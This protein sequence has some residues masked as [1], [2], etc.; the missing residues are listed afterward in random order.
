MNKIAH[1]VQAFFNIINPCNM[2]RTFDGLRASLR[3]W[4]PSSTSQQIKRPYF[5][6]LCSHQISVK[7][8]S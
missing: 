4:W 8:S 6:Y 3:F 7:F 2:D 1:P 5:L